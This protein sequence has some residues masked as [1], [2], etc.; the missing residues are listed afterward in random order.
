MVEAFRRPEE[1]AGQKEDLA[2]GGGGFVLRT[3]ALLD[4]LLQAADIDQLETERSCTGLIDPLATVLLGQA[5][6]LLCLAELRPGEG[7]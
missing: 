6:K 5:E 7:S 1:A 4:D 3:Q 2:L